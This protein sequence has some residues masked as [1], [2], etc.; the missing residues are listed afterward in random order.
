V[1][2]RNIEIVSSVDPKD[3][4]VSSVELVKSEL[5]PRILSRVNAASQFLLIAMGFGI[6]NGV[7]KFGEGWHLQ[8]S[9]PTTS[10]LLFTAFAFYSVRFFFNNWIYLSQSY[11]TES[12]KKIDDVHKLRAIL[13]C[14]HL[15]ML[16]SIIAGASCAFTGT[17]IDPSGDALVPIMTFLIVHYLADLFITVHNVKFRQDEKEMSI[18]KLFDQVMA[19][20]TNNIAF[21]ACLLM[22][23]GIIYSNNLDVSWV[24]KAFPGAWLV[25]SIIAIGITIYFSRR[26]MKTILGIQ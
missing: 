12:L 4:S 10:I 13:R 1:S 5:I 22:F 9:F 17:M 25:N 15:D 2:E 26:E 14:A 24:I 11:Y 21:V 18:S 16:L 3:E 6:T 20:I 19:W 8:K 7:I 23:V